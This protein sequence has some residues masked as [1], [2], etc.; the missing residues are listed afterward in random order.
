MKDFLKSLLDNA[1]SLLGYQRGSAQS[2]F[3]PDA[4]TDIDRTLKVACEDLISLVAAR[5]IS[6]LRSFLDKCTAYIA[7]SA[8]S[9]S[10]AKTDLS[11]Q[12]FATSEKVKEVHEEFKSICTKEIEDWKK[13]LRMYLLDEDTVAVLL[14]P[15][16]VS[17]YDRPERGRHEIADV[18]DLFRT[19]SLMVI[20]S[21]TTLSEPSTT[22]V[23]RQ[24]L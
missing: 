12:E 13:E 10:S 17:R 22:L 16:Y 6:P 4:R 1:S 18:Y 8:A 19:R 14:P 7:K 24:G 23:L 5:A 9:S 2:N 20:D 21:S 15:A 11:A 3:A